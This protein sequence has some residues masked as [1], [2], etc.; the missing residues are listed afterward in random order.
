I[1][2]R[3]YPDNFKVTAHSKLTVKKVI[4]NIKVLCKEPQLWL[5]SAYIALMYESITVFCGLW[6]NPFLRS[7]FNLDLQRSTFSCCL[8][9]AGI[10]I[11]SPI[12]GVLCDTDKRRSNCITVCA[13]A[14]F[15]IFSAILY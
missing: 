10:G 15:I 3:D 9:L 4:A 7:A 12:A 11:G 2:I 14:M 1:F 6:A 5:Q 8:V 13:I